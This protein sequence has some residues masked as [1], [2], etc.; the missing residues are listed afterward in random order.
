[1]LAGASAAVAAF[2]AEDALT[3]ASE[4]PGFGERGLRRLFDSLFS[5]GWCASFPAA[6]RSVS[7]AYGRLLMNKCPDIYLERRR[8]P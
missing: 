8:R 4:I 7:T 2:L 1:V 3:T 5:P 6:R